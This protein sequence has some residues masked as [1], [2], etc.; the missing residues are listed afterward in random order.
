[1]SYPPSRKVSA[2]LKAPWIK[3]LLGT[4]NSRDLRFGVLP[5]FESIRWALDNQFA[6]L[7]KLCKGAIFFDDPEPDTGNCN[8]SAAWF[9][10]PLKHGGHGYGSR[11]FSHA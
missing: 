5:I 3:V 8:T 11:G 6:T 9:A 1:M 7:A 4:D 10:N 2:V